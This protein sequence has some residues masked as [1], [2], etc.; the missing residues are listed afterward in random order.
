MKE[1]ITIQ[2][3][4]AVMSRIQ[5]LLSQQYL[6]FDTGNRSQL[7]ARC[8]FQNATLE[9]NL[10]SVDSQLFY[11]KIF[12]SEI[13]EGSKLFC[14]SDFRKTEHI[15]SGKVLSRNLT[16]STKEDMNNPQYLDPTTA[17]LMEV[18]IQ[19]SKTEVDVLTLGET[20]L[21]MDDKW[22]AYFDPKT[23]AMHY[24]HSWTGI[25]FY[26]FELNLPVGKNDLYE[27]RKVYLSKEWD[28]N[29]NLEE[30]K[31]LIIS[32]LKNDITGKLKLIE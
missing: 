1:S 28:W 27:I 25:E 20:S 24:F 10:L 22:Q 26:R 17:D 15:G 11:E 12:F 8:I 13:P 4:D 5:E 31:T 9:S 32:K 16:P 6:Y 7:P 3:D 19:L 29:W 2:L 30:K 14:F 23:R 21:S 18:D